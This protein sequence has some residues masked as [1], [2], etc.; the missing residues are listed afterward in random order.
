MV[1]EALTDKTTRADA[2]ARLQD[3]LKNRKTV[4]QSL[5]FAREP[6]QRLGFDTPS[7]HAAHRVSG[8]GPSLPSRPS[9]PPSLSKDVR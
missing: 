4:L 6:R 9:G 2:I 7:C 1:A 3:V 5:E 8:G